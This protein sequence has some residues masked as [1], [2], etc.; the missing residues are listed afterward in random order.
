MVV[1]DYGCLL[2]Q[3]S[4][5]IFHF[6]HPNIPSSSLFSNA[7]NP[8]FRYRDRRCLIQTQKRRQNNAS[9]FIKINDKLVNKNTKL[10]APRKIFPSTGAVF[11][12][13]NYYFMCKC[14]CKSPAA[15]R[16]RGVRG[17]GQCQYTCTSW[18]IYAFTLSNNHNFTVVIFTDKHALNCI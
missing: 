4:V 9:F 16:R 10:A 8:F 12:Q 18:L 7:L 17:P 6:S 5:L 2:E 3:V 15:A 13:S 11:Q 1:T 14:T